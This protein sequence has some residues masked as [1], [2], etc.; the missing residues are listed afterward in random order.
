MGGVGEGGCIQNGLVGR[1]DDQH[2]IGPAVQG[3]QGERGCGVAAYELEQ[4]GAQGAGSNFNFCLQMLILCHLALLEAACLQTFFRDAVW[5]EHIDVVKLVLALAEVLHLDPT[6]VDQC[7][8]AVVQ[9]TRA[10]A[11]FFGNLALGHVRVVFQHPQ[12]MEVGVFLNLGLAGGHLDL[13]LHASFGMLPSYRF[14]FGKRG[15]GV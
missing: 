6:L 10:D 5:R 7:L 15:K 9:A 13:G 2:W 1:G 8:Q 4:G 11:E 12:D 14:T 3:G